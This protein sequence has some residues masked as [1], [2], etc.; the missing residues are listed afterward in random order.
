MNVL[1]VYMV[2]LCL[3]SESNLLTLYPIKTNLMFKIVK[4]RGGQASANPVF[5]ITYPTTIKVH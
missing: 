2:T 1:V 5:V 3:F 4:T